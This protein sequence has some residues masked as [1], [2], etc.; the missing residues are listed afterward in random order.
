VPY[1]VGPQHAWGP[2][3]VNGTFRG[4]LPPA[5][6]AVPFIIVK[7]MVII[8]T[9][10]GKRAAGFAGCG[11]WTRAGAGLL[12]KSVAEDAPVLSRTT[13]VW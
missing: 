7:Q 3:S 5:A 13:S 6:S 8:L 11:A 10:Q 2:N 1:A 12:S 9:E 4:S